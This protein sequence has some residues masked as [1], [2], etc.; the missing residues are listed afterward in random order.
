MLYC[1]QWQSTHLK[2]QNLEKKILSG[3]H[4]IFV[5]LGGFFWGGEVENMTK[6]VLLA[7]GLTHRLFK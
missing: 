4:Q 7:F 5:R 1:T 6:F 2:K 3:K